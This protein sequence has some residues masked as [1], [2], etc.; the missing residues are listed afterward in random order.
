MTIK[1]T[2]IFSLFLAILSISALSGCATRT[3]VEAIQSDRQQDRNR[4]RQLEAELAESRQQLK[5]EIEQSNN[6]IRERSADMWAEIQSLRTEIAKMRGEMDNL[7]IRMDRQVGAADSAVTVDDLARRLSEVEFAMENQLQ[8]D[9]P[10]I[11]EERNAAMAAALP[12]ATPEANAPLAG[13]A[14]AKSAENGAAAGAAAA[15]GTAAAADK[16]DSAPQADNDPAKALYDKAYALYKDGN[17][18]RA[19]SYWAEFTDTFKGHAFTPSA[20]FWQGQCYYMLKDYARAVILYEDV[21]EKY[22]KSSKYKSALLRAGYSWE[23]IGKPE[24]AKMRFQEV[25]QNF[26]KSVEATQAKRSLDKMK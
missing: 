8:V 12:A 7:N 17:Y 2:C 15:V 20:V 10:K 9:L 1:K 11:R 3:D 13:Q 18:E 14:E 26:P 16:N 22:K 24:L 25:I 6:P 21:I 4:I 19:R 5:E 23:H